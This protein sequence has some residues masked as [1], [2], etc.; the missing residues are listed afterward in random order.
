MIV[1]N[2]SRQSR[3]DAFAHTDKHF[4]LC[5]QEYIQTKDRDIVI[6][7]FAVSVILALQARMHF[8]YSIDLAPLQMDYHT[9]V[10]SVAGDKPSYEMV[11]SDIRMTSG[12]FLTVD[13]STAFHVNTYHIII[14]QDLQSTVS[15]FSCFN[16]FTWDVWMV[17]ILIVVYAG[18]L[19]Y[20]FEPAD[21]QAEIDHPN[22]LSSCKGIVVTILKVTLMTNEAPYKTYASQFVVLNLYILCAILTAT[23]TANLASFLILNHSEQTK[24]GIDDLKNGRIPFTR[25]GIVTNSAVSDY[26][27]QDI[28]PTY[29]RLGT[30]QEIYQRLLDNTIDASIWDS[31]ILE[32][33]IDEHYCGIFQTTGTGFLQ[34]SFGIAVPKS[35]RYKKDLDSNI[36]AL[37]DSQQLE[38]LEEIWFD[39]RKCTASFDRKKR[40]QLIGIETFSMGTMAGAFF[41]F[42]VVS[43]AAM[44][45]FLGESRAAVLNACRR[46]DQRIVPIGT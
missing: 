34:S 29:Y 32:H 13:F 15:L 20:L 4:D 42:L 45:I 35:W 30:A 1:V 11:I 8:N 38:R 25:I 3:L 19:I 7:G 6:C 16:P 21:P 22:L 17:T 12:R 31:P 44:G 46:Q 40:V 2:V 26:Y 24:L 37:R 43:V 23:Y 14:R 39:P 10:S 27:E 28:S 36:L 5:N 9:L 33:A 41:V 18:F